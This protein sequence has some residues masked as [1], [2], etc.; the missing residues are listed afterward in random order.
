M[1]DLQDQLVT[2]Y[3]RTAK[4]AWDGYPDVQGLAQLVQDTVLE[5]KMDGITPT[6]YS[7]SATGL[8]IPKPSKQL[9][10]RLATLMTQL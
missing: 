6:V 3:E 4:T 9:R 5:L 1:F 8:H 2:D 7:I 10:F